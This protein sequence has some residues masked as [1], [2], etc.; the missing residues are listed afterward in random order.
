[1]AEATRDM[2]VVGAGIHGAGIAQAAAAAGHDVL[3]LEMNSPA[4]GTSGRSSKLIHGGLRYLETARFALVRESLRDRNTLLRIAPGLVREV[5]FHIPVYRQTRRRPWQFRI[6]LGIYRFL[7]GL[8]AE[9]RIETVPSGEWSMLD[10]LSTDGLQVVYR[11]MDARTDDVALTRAVLGSAVELGAELLCP[12]RMVSAVKEKGI[13]R[14]SFQTGGH[15]EEIGCRVLI[16]AAGP[17]VGH[18]SRSVSPP[19]ADV[20]VELVQGS[21]VEVTGRLTQGVYYAEAPSDGRAVLVMPWKGNTLVGTTE[22]PFRGD[23][24]LVS[25]LPAELSYLLEVLSHYFPDNPGEIIGSFAGI[26][27]LPGGGGGYFRRSR[28]VAL[29]LDDR[30]RPGCATIYGGKLTTYLSTAAKVL[31]LVRRSLPARRP[32]A[33]VNEITLS[34]SS[35]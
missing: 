16:N 32:K 27:V 6:G 33:D 4:A 1:M 17:W 34:G 14:V 3:V 18:V 31:A 10:G 35:L 5:P 29:A 25:P 9:N 30:D 12:A 20:D 8:K 2:V 24:D 15:T 26:R 13:Y 28:E 7:E 11:Y 23:P 21:H 19:S 22:T